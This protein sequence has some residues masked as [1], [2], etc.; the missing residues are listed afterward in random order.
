M[1]EEEEEEEEEG[2]DAD[3]EMEDGDE[4]DEDGEDD[5]SDK[6]GGFPWGG[7]LAGSRGGVREANMERGRVGEE[8]AGLPRVELEREREWEGNSGT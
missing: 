7:C 1:E 2:D 6:S 3:K 8:E 5:D 4:D